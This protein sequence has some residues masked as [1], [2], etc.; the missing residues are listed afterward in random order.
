MLLAAA[1][2]SSFVSPRMLMPR[3]WAE[4]LGA[5]LAEKV[6]SGGAMLRHWR[7]Q[8]YLGGVPGVNTCEEGLHVAACRV[9]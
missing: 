4:R 1:Q 2:L 3:D 7:R 8:Q 5:A 6:A 9:K